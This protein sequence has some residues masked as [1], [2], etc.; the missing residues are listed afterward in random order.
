MK[1]IFL[2]FLTAALL[3][4]CTSCSKK[5]VF[6][7]DESTSM[8]FTS[9]SESFSQDNGTHMNLLN[10]FV[11]ITNFTTDEN[12][13]KDGTFSTSTGITIGSTAKDF[14]D[15]YSIN[16]GY[17]IWECYNQ[18]PDK[19]DIAVNYIPFDGSFITYSHH[20]DRFL[21]VGFAKDEYGK[22]YTLDSDALIEVWELEA[23]ES[24][25]YDVAIIC[26]AFDEKGIINTI[27]TDYGSYKDFKDFYTPSQEG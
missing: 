19:T 17:A 25:Y 23:D 9:S 16:P 12:V 1:K 24:L 2:L 15:A 10:N 26:A 3:V 8:V 14:V 11:S 20:F 4:L 6:T 22:W 13:T 21:V 18:L 27:Y 5:E 7:F